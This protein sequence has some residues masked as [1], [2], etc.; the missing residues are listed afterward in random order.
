MSSAC[1]PGEPSRSAM[2]PCCAASSPARDSR[3]VPRCCGAGASV[4]ARA[5][6]WPRWGPA[7]AL[8][9]ASSGPCCNLA[10]RRVGM[11]VVRKLAATATAAAAWHARDRQPASRARQRSTMTQ[12]AHT[13]S[14]RQAR[15]PSPARRRVL[16]SEASAS[17]FSTPTYD[18]A[19]RGLIHLLS[20]FEEKE[21]QAHTLTAERALSRRRGRDSVL[22]A[23]DAGVRL[24]R[25]LM[26]RC[27]APE[28][29]SSGREDL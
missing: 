15:S 13:P 10:V 14:A 19:A 24:S 12:A 8:L 9:P 4:P 7:T 16:A 20:A 23:G 27:T 11:V 28:S 22:R 18:Q 1:E 3:P 6:R 25:R 5:C 29:A 21:V 17:C 2:R 26:P